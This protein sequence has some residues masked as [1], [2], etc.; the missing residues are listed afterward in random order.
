MVLLVV[1]VVVVLLVVV[2]LFLSLFRVDACGSWASVTDS[3]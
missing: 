1:L 3:P 2:L